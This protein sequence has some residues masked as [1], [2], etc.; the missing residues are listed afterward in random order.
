MYRLFRCVKAF[1]R[2]ILNLP[3]ITFLSASDITHNAEVLVLVEKLAITH[4]QMKMYKAFWDCSAVALVLVKLP[5][6]D[7]LDVNPA[8]C[9]MYGYTRDEAIGKNVFAIA[10][11]PAQMRVT[12]NEKVTHINLRYHKRKNGGVFPISASLVYFNDCGYDV[13]GVSLIEKRQLD[14]RSEQVVML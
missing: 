11:D 1:I 6:G 14:R 10:E 8:A 4:K 3:L 13:V 2:R 9:G 12:L 5:D 7:I